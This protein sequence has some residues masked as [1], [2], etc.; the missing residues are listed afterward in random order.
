MENKSTQR[1]KPN[2]SNGDIYLANFNPEYIN[3]K[4][5]SNRS[6][7]KFKANSSKETLINH[8][9]NKIT[10]SSQIPFDNPNL[11]LHTDDHLNENTIQNTNQD[12]NH[13]ENENKD[14]QEDQDNNYQSNEIINHLPNEYLRNNEHIYQKGNKNSKLCSNKHSRR[15]P[16][17]P[18]NA[19][20]IISSPEVSSESQQ[21]KSLIPIFSPVKIQSSTNTSNSN[22]SSATL[23]SSAPASPANS[24]LTS[25]QTSSSPSSHA[26]SSLEQ[27]PQN[28]QENLS[29]NTSSY[30][31][32]ESEELQELEEIE[33]PEEPG[34]PEE[35]E[36]KGVQEE[37][38]VHPEQSTDQVLKNDDNH[39]NSP[40]E[41]EINPD[42]SCKTINNSITQSSD[43]I[44][45]QDNDSNQMVYAGQE[46]SKVLLQQ[47]E[48]KSNIGVVTFN[49]QA[50]IPPQ[51][52]QGQP[53]P[54]QKTMLQQ[55]Q[56]MYQQ[57]QMTFS[58]NMK[59]TREQY[60]QQMLQQQCIQQNLACLNLQLAK[61]KQAEL[62]SNQTYYY[63]TQ[64]LIQQNMGNAS[65]YD[66]NITKSKITQCQQSL[67]VAQQNI[68]QIE[69]Q[70]Q[71][72]QNQQMISK[73]AGSGNNGMCQI[74]MYQQ[75]CKIQN[76]LQDYNALI[77]KQKQELQGG[78]INPHQ[79]QQ[80]QNE[81]KTSL[82]SLIQ[83]TDN[84]I[85]N[86]QIQESE[87]TSNKQTNAK[88]NRN[89]PSLQIEFRNRKNLDIAKKD[90]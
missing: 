55:Q 74:Q 15:A 67:R 51:A 19:D 28:K 5:L 81:Q 61:N 11:I 14:Q 58:R 1:N 50:F 73:F 39:Q 79:L 75:L 83:L 44:K 41:Y 25:S 38:L 18:Q 4:F 68:K 60:N 42:F 16:R 48:Q 80:M 47:Q 49:Q 89:N 57:Q 8:Q 9:D 76:V 78:I 72:Y 20:N 13:K 63:L 6:E 2:S 31:V 33:E 77:E 30:A 26:L 12:E 70:I 3:K 88:E 27:T 17:P 40:E 29:S 86:N 85:L 82:Q 90:K 43:N 87:K 24:P 54:Q 32:S 69:Q 66:R 53:Q 37:I 7:S 45:N 52:V 59:M 64:Q 65:V 22:L 23:S 84:Q 21:A 56:I 46:T 62:T 35:S 34:E 10:I 71:F 36:E